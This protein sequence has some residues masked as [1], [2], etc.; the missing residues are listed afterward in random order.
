MC[1]QDLNQGGASGGSPDPTINL[2]EF[3]LDPA[4]QGQTIKCRITR[5]KKGMDRGI[6]PT[7]YLHMERDDG[8]KVG[9]ALWYC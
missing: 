5:D 9:P 7:Y 1:L 4:P 2:E 8:K 3:V 6:Y